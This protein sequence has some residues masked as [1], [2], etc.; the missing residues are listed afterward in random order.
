LGKSITLKFIAPDFYNKN[1][2]ENPRSIGERRNCGIGLKKLP[3]A[4][5]L[6]LGNEW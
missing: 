5:K 1:Q 3:R 6:L 4:N 2:L